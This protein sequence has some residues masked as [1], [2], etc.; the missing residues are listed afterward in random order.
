MPRNT[1]F[2]IHIHRHIFYR[3]WIEVNKMGQQLF[4]PCLVIFMGTEEVFYIQWQN[5][6]VKSATFYSY[7]LGVSI[8]A[9]CTGKMRL[10]LQ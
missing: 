2:H 6:D 10:T 1:Y 3:R 4:I 9:S 5:L 8:L 7:Q